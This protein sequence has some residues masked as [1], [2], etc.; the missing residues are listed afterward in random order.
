MFRPTL[1]RRHLLLTAVALSAGA[2]LEGCAPG[3]GPTA[4][5]GSSHPA[6]GSAAAGGGGAIT[7][8]ALLDV[9]PGLSLP[10]TAI[11]KAPPWFT[12][13]MAAF[14][15]R[16]AAGRATVVA[17]G[18]STPDV[19]GV[20]SSVFES[21]VFGTPPRSPARALDLAGVAR[22]ANQSLPAVLPA[23][24]H[25]FTGYVRSPS[26]S[27]TYAPLAG[28][29]AAPLL[30]HNFCLLANVDLLQGLGLSLPQRFVQY[31]QLQAFLTEVSLGLAK[32]G[33]KLAALDPFSASSPAAFQSVF[34]S[35]GGTIGSTARLDLSTTGNAAGLL[36]Y[37]Q[38]AAHCRFGRF[39]NG[40]AVCAFAWG[41]VGPGGGLSGFAQGLPRALRC[42][43]ALLPADPSGRMLRY[44][45]GITLR[46]G[47]T[48]KRELTA[49]DFLTWASADANLVQLSSGLG[50]APA[51][52]SADAGAWLSGLANVGHRDLLGAGIRTQ[53]SAFLAPLM[54]ESSVLTW[55][56][57]A[58]IPFAR[59]AGEYTPN[60][61]RAVLAALRTRAA[62]VGALQLSGAPG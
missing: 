8:A 56:Q 22:L 45:G 20:D 42:Q 53:P 51:T 26:A 21:W 10:P 2:L 54:Q 57:T 44:V 48:G 43:V 49:W 32:R 47:L 19:N 28:P 1:A 61:A 50:L 58:V 14:N 7:V 12:D 13:W 24:A 52:P 46:A 30:W 15:H 35:A 37:A 25:A 16:G 39:L 23:L 3:A 41:G 60:A 40:T 59:T 17:A 4:G 62:T 31:E 55:L 29:Y 38:L 5:G 27:G 11:R 33:S 36:A 18:P 6:S 34:E 9:V